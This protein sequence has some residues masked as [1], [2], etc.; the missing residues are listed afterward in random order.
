VL[1][2][3]PLGELPAWLQL[4]AGYDLAMLLAGGLTYGLALEE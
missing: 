1:A 4:L 2:G 3:D